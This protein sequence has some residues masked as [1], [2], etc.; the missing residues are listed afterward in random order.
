MGNLGE[1][2]VRNMVGM[3]FGD[4]LFKSVSVLAT[5][6]LAFITFASIN[7]TYVWFEQEACILF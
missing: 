5:N 7:R 4:V 1:K 6:I 2:K 3:C